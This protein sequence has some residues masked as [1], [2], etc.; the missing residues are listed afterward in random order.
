MEIQT[1]NKD[2][3]IMISVSWN[4]QTSKKPPSLKHLMMMG[5]TRGLE[6]LFKSRNRN[7]EKLWKCS[8]VSTGENKNRLV[9]FVCIHCAHASNLPRLTISADQV[10][11]T[12]SH[13][14][15]WDNLCRNWNM[16][17]C[18]NIQTSN[19]NNTMSTKI[20]QSMVLVNTASSW[21]LNYIQR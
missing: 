10:E 4:V 1:V 6:V 7:V 19:N 20:E 18:G 16:K 11:E 2:D 8:K 3:H 9:K 5:L 15:L 14:T 12:R 17:C 13:Q 21:E